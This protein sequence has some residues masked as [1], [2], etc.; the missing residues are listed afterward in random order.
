MPVNYAGLL[1]ELLSLTD[2]AELLGMSRQGA[3]KLVK[4]EAT[5]PA[6]AVLSG[7][8]RV[9]K[10]GDVEAWARDTGRTP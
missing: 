6:P 9:W 1:M 5:F 8:T 7:G 10:R 4:R 2:I 3:D